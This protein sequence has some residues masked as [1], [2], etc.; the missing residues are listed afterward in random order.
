MEIKDKT[1]EGVWKKVLKALLE[2]GA[3]FKDRKE[4]QCREISNMIVTIESSEDIAK[5][6]EIL[7]SL[8]KWVYPPIEELKASI[9]EKDDIPGYYYHYGARAFCYNGIDQINDFIIPLFKTAPLSKRGVIV[10]FQPDKDS[11]VAKKEIPG[12]LTM[13]FNIRNSKLNTTTIIR[14]NDFFYGWPGNVVQCFFLAEYISKEL[15][16]PIGTMTTISVSAHIFK[17]QFEDI[18]KVLKE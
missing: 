10:F 8:K 17:D 15:N 3:D 12:M 11:I 16:I 7:N 18:K 1:A 6:I 13:N 4:R 9:L 14:S 5:P 2:N